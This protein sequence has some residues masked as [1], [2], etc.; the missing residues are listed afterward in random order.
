MN[1]VAVC[2]TDRSIGFGCTRRVPAKVDDA[3]HDV[4]VGQR[5][6]GEFLK[7][8]LLCV[9][10]KNAFQ[11]ATPR[12]VLKPPTPSQPTWPSLAGTIRSLNGGLC[13]VGTVRHRDGRLLALIPV[14]FRFLNFARRGLCFGA[15][16]RRHIRI[17]VLLR[18]IKFVKKCLC[19]GPCSLRCVRTNY[20]CSQR[21][22]RFLTILLPL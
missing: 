13:I 18:V 22:Q 9:Q 7:G 16:C 17:L 19:F 3:C 5:L 15:C 11:F 1:F 12:R 10:R 21:S 2:I 6:Q 4:A 14:S 8:I 20:S